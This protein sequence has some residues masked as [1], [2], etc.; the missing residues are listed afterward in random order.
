[1][2]FLGFCSYPLVGVVDQLPGS[3]HLVTGEGSSREGLG[4]S[5]GDA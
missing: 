2:S 4:E 1:M 5:T 3:A